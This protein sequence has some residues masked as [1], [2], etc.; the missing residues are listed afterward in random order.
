MAS[1]DTEYFAKHLVHHTIRYRSQWHIQEFH[2]FNKCVP[3][4]RDFKEPSPYGLTSLATVAPVSIGLVDGVKI[5]RQADLAGSYLCDDRAD[6][7]MGFHGLWSRSLCRSDFE[8]EGITTVLRESTHL[9]T[10]C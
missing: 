7:S 8:S 1:S 3:H 4:R 9:S 5:H 10:A 2:N 6:R